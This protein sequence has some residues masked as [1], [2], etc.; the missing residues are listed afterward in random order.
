MSV[1]EQKESW[2]MSRR[3][4]LGGTDAAAVLGLSPWRRPI[5]VW[6]DKVHPERRVDLDKDCLR[7]GV[8]LEPVIREEYARRFNVQVIDPCDLGVL[9]PKSSRWEDSTIIT[10]RYPWMLG[11]PDGY[12]A[13]EHTGLEIKTAGRR[14]EEWGD[15]DTDEIPAQYLMQCVWYMATT[16]TPAWNLAVLFAGSDLRQY[17]IKRDMDLE[18]DTISACREFWEE[19]IAKRVEPPIDQSES[20]GRYL[21]RKFSLNTGKIL[22]PTPD[23]IHWTMRMKL[24]DDQEKEAGENKQF[25]N[26]QLRALVGDA[27]KCVTPL[28]TIGWVRPETKDATNWS[29]V[30][31]KVGPLHPEV[32]KEFTAPKEITA[33]LRAWWRK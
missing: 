22:Q 23:I 24:A 9:F 29:E 4:G 7:W 32:V 27:Q 30:G 33:Y 11:M 16:E 13:N 20:Y 3:N 12:L 17:R 31:K 5:E 21:A 10:G 8:L 18:R 19:Y 25:A 2:A 1:V 28:G 15:A 14:S 6:E 26:N